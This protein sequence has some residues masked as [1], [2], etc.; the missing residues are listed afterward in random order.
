MSFVRLAA[1]LLAS[2]GALALS[3]GGC[4][5]GDA[6]VGGECATGY[7][8]C[9]FACVDLANDPGNCGACGAVCQAGTSC[10]ASACV[11]HGTD[12]GDAGDTGL[13]SKDGAPPGTV[14]A[15]VVPVTDAGSG[16]DGG[17]SSLGDAAANAA[18]GDDGS[19]FDGAPLGD[20]ATD[21][22]SDAAAAA[23][24]SRCAPPL[25]ACSA[26]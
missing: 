11:A 18:T 3:I 2:W 20:A 15:P 14:V 4:G 23:D 17:A 9:D 5:A 22:A 8:Q 24:A 21:D 10:V 26:Q 1:T 25:I 12:V 7:A 13:S 16:G 6:L 19:T